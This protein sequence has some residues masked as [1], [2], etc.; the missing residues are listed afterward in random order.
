[1]LGIP[2]Q[3]L[4]VNPSMRGAIY[5]L[6]ASNGMTIIFVSCGSNN[7]MEK[8]LTEITV[9][10]YHLDLYKHVN[11][12]RYLEFLEEARW[13]RFSRPFEKNGF[14]DMGLA[15]VIVNININYRYPAKLGDVVVIDTEVKRVGAKSIVIGQAMTL[16][17]DGRPVVDAEVTVVVMDVVKERAVPIEGR[18]LELLQ[19]GL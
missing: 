6:S 8:I 15:L 5:C 12:A 4:I 9:R 13:Q 16:K 11:N 2:K 17:A 1:M 3:L 18:V 10:G 7:P 19:G 14:D